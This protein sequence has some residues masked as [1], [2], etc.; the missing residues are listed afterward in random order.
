MS[1]RITISS[2]APW[3]PLVGYSR[4][5]RVGNEI[6]VSGTTAVDENGL[7]MG[8]G[9]PHAQTRRILSIIQKALEDAGSGLADVVRTRIY[10]TDITQWEEIGRAHGEF[11]GDI[12]PASTMVGVNALIDPDML[13]EIE[14]TA[15]V[16]R[17]PDA[18]VA[19]SSG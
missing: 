19:S 15:I 3:E 4:A 14:A 10:A 11:F 13:V 17:T 16:S 12:R 5:V 7:L 8:L 9:D 2:G 1:D 18:G 6:H